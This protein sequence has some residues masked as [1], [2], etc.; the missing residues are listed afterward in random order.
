M[1]GTHEFGMCQFFCHDDGNVAL[2]VARAGLTLLKNENAVLPLDKSKL[3]NI[4]V[5]GPNAERTPV[6]GG[7]SGYT[8]PFHSVSIVDGLRAAGIEVEVGV[9]AEGALDLLMSFHGEGRAPRALGP[10]RVMVEDE[11]GGSVFAW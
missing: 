7:G 1:N 11:T 5:I 9:G 8:T 2:D 4:V 10:A 3:K 6:G